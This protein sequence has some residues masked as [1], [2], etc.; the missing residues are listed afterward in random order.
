MKGRYWHEGLAEGHSAHSGCRNGPIT[1]TA[2][3]DLRP[4]A[5][6]SSVGTQHRANVLLAWTASLELHQQA[7]STAKSKLVAQVERQTERIV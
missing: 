3:V 6:R 4:I 5:G 2:Q 7:E 1:V